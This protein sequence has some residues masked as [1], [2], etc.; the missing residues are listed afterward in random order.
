MPACGTIFDWEKKEA[1]RKELEVRRNDPKLW[2][3]PEEAREIM[4]ELSSLEEEG[5]NFQKLQGELDTAHE[6]LEL[7][8]LSAH[9]T[10]ALEDSLDHIETVLVRSERELLL[11]EPSS[12]V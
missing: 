11:G 4:Q 6:F 12:F 2:D 10:K 8:E 3:K 5:V 7:G 1:R 9:D